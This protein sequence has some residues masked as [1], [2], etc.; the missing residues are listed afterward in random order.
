M[1]YHNIKLELNTNKDTLEK[2]RFA[3]KYE[4]LT[5][6]GLLLSGT[7]GGGNSLL[8]L[9]PVWISGSFSFD[10]LMAY[11]PPRGRCRIQGKVAEKLVLN[12]K[13]HDVFIKEPIPLHLTKTHQYSVSQPKL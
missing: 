13:N 8:E 5:L 11:I 4:R 1:L 6:V 3:F 10:V 9:E 12:H 7:Q 2:T